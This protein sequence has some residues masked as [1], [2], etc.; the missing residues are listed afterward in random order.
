[1]QHVGQ[2]KGLAMPSACRAHSLLR[3]QAVC[4]CI[5]HDCLLVVGDSFTAG[6]WAQAL[7]KAL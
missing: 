2:T 6:G 4:H 1:M 3:K 5:G 7:F